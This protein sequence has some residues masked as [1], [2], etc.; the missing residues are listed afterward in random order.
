M[1]P[2]NKSVC[3]SMWSASELTHVSAMHERSLHDVCNP[4]FAKWQLKPRLEQVPL[5]AR[6]VLC[7]LLSIQTGGTFR[8][9]KEPGKLRA[10]SVL[11]K[12]LLACLHF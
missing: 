1:A 3:K 2:A 10:P 12:R 5:P 7:D 4:C 9:Y 6:L 11:I 8:R